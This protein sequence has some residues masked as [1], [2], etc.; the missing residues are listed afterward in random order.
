MQK[1]F[2]LEQWVF[3]GGRMLFMGYHSTEDDESSIPFPI[4]SVFHVMPYTTL[5]VVIHFICRTPRHRIT[6]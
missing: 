5:G 4:N 2:A 1:L 3:N 6:H